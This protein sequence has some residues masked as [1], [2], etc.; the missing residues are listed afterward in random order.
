MPILHE[1][2]INRPYGAGVTDLTSFSLSDL[3][4]QY[5]SSNNLK[6]ELHQYRKHNPASEKIRTPTVT[7]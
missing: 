1:Q 5:F 6:D 4:F 3:W 7:D 2:G